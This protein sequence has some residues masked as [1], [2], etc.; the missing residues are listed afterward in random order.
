M[1]VPQIDST[2][3][4]SREFFVSLGAPGLVVLGFLEFFFFPLPPMFVVIPLTVAHPELAVVYALSAA[5]GSVIA[6]VVGFTIGRKGGRRVVTS[7]FPERRVDQAERY[8]DEHG[9]A[10]VALGAFAPIPEAHELLSIG[11]GAFSMRLGTYVAAAALGRG[12]KYFLVAGLGVALGRTARSLTEAEIYS[13]IGVV[14]VV[15]VLAY[16]SRDYWAPRPTW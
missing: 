9:F 10:T 3:E 7:R 6:G 12:A 5:T 14:V 16:A 15:V 2:I 13:V 4:V 8:V 1:Q 11:A